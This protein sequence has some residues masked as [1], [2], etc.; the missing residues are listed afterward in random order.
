MN[1]EQMSTFVRSQADTDEDDAPDVDLSVY[2]R[3]AYRDIQSRV[4]PWPSKKV[5]YTFETVAGTSGYSFSAFSGGPDM[6]FVLR[7]ADG[8]E[9]L[10][11][12]SPEQFAELSAGSSGSATVYSVIG[13]QIVL[14]PTPNAAV[15]LT[16]SGYRDFAE[17]PAG[18]DEP[19]LPRGFDEAICWYMLSL[20][21]KKQEDLELAENYMR[22]FEIAVN[23]QIEKALRS[24]SVSA[25]PM[26]FGG[27]PRLHSP[28]SYEDWVKRNVEGS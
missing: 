5:E 27:D 10:I 26:I 14:W 6:E 4:F 22:D 21:Y 18:S 25:G 11:Y 19:D 1:L 13:S 24:S 15:T 2:A 20:F 23:R 17:W 12:V 7:V 28:V 16:V 3:A 9:L 8:D